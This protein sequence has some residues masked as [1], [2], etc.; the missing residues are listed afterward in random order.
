MAYG[1]NDD[2]SKVNLTYPL[3]ELLS[4]YNVVCKYNSSENKYRIFIPIDHNSQYH[5]IQ[6]SGVYVLYEGSIRNISDY[7]AL[8]T[9]TGLAV[10]FTSEIDFSGYLGNV[11]MSFF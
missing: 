10:T 6:V 7:V 11:E 3:N 5:G 9:T 4:F 2:K 8:K 1:F